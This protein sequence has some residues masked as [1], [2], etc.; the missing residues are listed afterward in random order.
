MTMSCAGTLAGSCA[1]EF[2]AAA[3]RLGALLSGKFQLTIND[4]SPL[5]GTLCAM[6]VETACG[7]ATSSFWSTIGA[8]RNTGYLRIVA[9]NVHRKTLQ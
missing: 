8:I 1:T 3:A 6:A 5:D 7:C 4:A 2:R 9:V